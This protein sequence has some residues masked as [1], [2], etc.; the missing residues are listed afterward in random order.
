M[1]N[2][3][4]LRS[5]RDHVTTLT[6]NQPARLNGWTRPMLEALFAALDE[7]AADADTRAVILTGAD[8]YYCAGVNLSETLG[9]RHPRELRAYIAE[10]NRLLFERFLAFPKPILA[11]VNGPAIGASVTSASLCDAIVASERA[12]F[13]TPFAALGVPAEGCSS[14]MFPRLLGDVAAARMLGPEG[15]KPTAAEALEI[16]LV[17]RV[18]PH[19]ALLD[20][21]QRLA[22]GWVAGGAAR[23]F[24][25]GA[26]REELDAINAAESERVA[27]AFLD[28]PFLRGQASFLWRKKKRRAAMLFLGLWLT[29]PAWA[30]LL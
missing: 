6:L 18:V 26:T 2:D 4:V 14:V 7:A 20:E 12:T 9:V 3:L 17:Q 10:H 23:T 11:A 1:A 24:R 22:A 29:R 30:L 21:A 19:E 27:D 25:G 8:P 5:S 28:A 16:G 15:W 13:S